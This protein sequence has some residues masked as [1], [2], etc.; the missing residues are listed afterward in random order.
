MD[1]LFT[2]SPD[3]RVDN[4]SND[5]KGLKLPCSWLPGPL[6]CR[7]LSYS[8]ALLGSATNISFLQAPRGMAKGKGIVVGS[9]PMFSLEDFVSLHILNWLCSLEPLHECWTAIWAYTINSLIHCFAFAAATAAFMRA[10]DSISSLFRCSSA[11][12]NANDLA[13][14]SKDLSQDTKTLSEL[15]HDCQSKVVSSEKA[16]QNE[17]FWFRWKSIELI[18]FKA[19]PVILCEFR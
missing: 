17:Y 13:S 1:R 9:H 11:C 18:Q 16:F 3:R 7:A 8:T 5:L 12:I 10:F 2:V 15:H 19:I 14:S 6:V 4:H